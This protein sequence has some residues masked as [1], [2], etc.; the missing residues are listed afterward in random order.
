MCFIYSKFTK[1]T[2][3]KCIFPMTRFHFKQVFYKF[4]WVISV[5]CIHYIDYIFGLY[6]K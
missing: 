3:F 4:N 5:L 6:Q 2:K 1:T